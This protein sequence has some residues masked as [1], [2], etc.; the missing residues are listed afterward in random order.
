MLQDLGQSFIATAVVIGAVLRANVIRCGTVQSTVK[1]V[2]VKL[3]QR[4]IV[5]FM[6]ALEHKA[7]IAVGM[8]CWLCILCQ[9][10]TS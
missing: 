8:S 9:A 5:A 7:S 3:N 1:S 6:T 4:L 10:W 2:L